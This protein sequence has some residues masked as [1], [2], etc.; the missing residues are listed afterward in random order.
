MNNYMTLR[1]LSEFLQVSR[2]TIYSWIQQKKIPCYKVD[3]IYR[4]DRMQIAMWMKQKERTV[5]NEAN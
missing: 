4:F 2:P 3:G 5:E 1:E